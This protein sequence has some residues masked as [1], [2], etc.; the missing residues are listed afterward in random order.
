[1][2]KGSWSPAWIGRMTGRAIR[3]EFRCY[4]V[5]ILG[6]LVGS[7]VTAIAIFRGIFKDSTFVTKRAVGSDAGMCPR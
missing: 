1:M 5:R 2:V 3:G 4:M 7:I 6:S